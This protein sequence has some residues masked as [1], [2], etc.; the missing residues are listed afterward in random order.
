[1]T[2]KMTTMTTKCCQ[3]TTKF[4]LLVVI[5]AVTLVVIISD[6]CRLTAH[7]HTLNLFPEVR[8]YMPMSAN[9]VA[10]RIRIF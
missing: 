3:T 6:L 4:W 10:L 5:L 7:T 2:T 8:D 9:F 1:M